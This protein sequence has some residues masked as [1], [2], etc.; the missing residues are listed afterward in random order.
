MIIFDDLPSAIEETRWI[1]PIYKG[2]KWTKM[3]YMNK[4]YAMAT[5][6]T[7]GYM[8]AFISGSNH[9]IAFFNE[10]AS[11]SAEKANE[12]FTLVSF[13]ACAAWNDNLHLTIVGYRNSTQVNTHTS[14]LLFGKP[15]IIL[16][17]WQNID[18]IVFQPTGDTAHLE[19]REAA[20]DTHCILT[21][22]IV[23]E[24]A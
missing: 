4:S 6:P 21:Q 9:N 17:Q 14:I 1:P 19:N 18:K 20:S 8:A 23:N 10:E 24:L 12:T 5:Y 2:L 3:V 7:S 13:T 22:L 15:Q 16:L 11:I